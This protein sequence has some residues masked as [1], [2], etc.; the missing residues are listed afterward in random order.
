MKTE[1][2]TNKNWLLRMAEAEDNCELAVGGLAHDVGLF[3]QP[4]D[5]SFAPPTK[6]AFARL[7]ELRRRE[8]RLSVEQLA[9]RADVELPELLDIV[10]GELSSPPEVRTVFNLATALKLPEQRLM[11]L[12]GLAEPK[13]EGF[14]EAAVRFAAR[15][16]S[17]DK[18]TRE[19][20]KALEEFVKFLAEK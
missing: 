2:S 3:E 9:E 1:L 19:E 11:Q 4:Q 8:Q 15:S 13:D 16:E 12:A 18:L 10:H 14:T 6:S 20:H 17:I 7:I 5:Q